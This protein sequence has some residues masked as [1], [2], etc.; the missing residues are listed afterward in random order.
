M[1]HSDICKLVMGFLRNA[2]YYEACSAIQIESGLGQGIM[3]DELIYLQKLTLQGRWDDTLRYLQPMRRVLLHNFDML[4]CMIKKQQY[5][6]ALSWLGAGGQRHSLMP[7]RPPAIKNKGDR[8]SGSALDES[9]MTF[10]DDQD[11][12]DMESVASLLKQLEGRCPQSEFNHLCTLLTLERLGDDEKYK[13]WSVARGRLACFRSLRNTLYKILPGDNDALYDD[14]NDPYEGG[15]LAHLVT[16]GTAIE[17]HR[18][19]YTAGAGPTANEATRAAAEDARLTQS[20]THVPPSAS[21]HDDASHGNASRSEIED[22][23]AEDDFGEPLNANLNTSVGSNIYFQEEDEIARQ[24]VEADDVK[25]QKNIDAAADDVSAECEDDALFTITAS[26]VRKTD[27]GDRNYT[28][29]YSEEYVSAR[30]IYSS[31]PSSPTELKQEMPKTTN[32]RTVESEPPVKSSQDGNTQII[33]D[34]DNNIEIHVPKKPKGSMLPVPLS[35]RN[36][37]RFTS[38]NSVASGESKPTSWTVDIGEGSPARRRPGSRLNLGKDSPRSVSSS[39]S[40]AS[41]GTATTVTAPRRAPVPVQK[42]PQ[43]GP[44]VGQYS[45]AEPAHYHDAP[46]LP[47]PPPLPFE[48]HVA[49]EPSGSTSVASESVYSARHGSPDKLN[50]MSRATTITSST[51]RTGG[52]LDTRATTFSKDSMS[53]QPLINQRGLNQQNPRTSTTAG[54]KVK[55]VTAPSGERSSQALAYHKAWMCSNNREPTWSVFQRAPCPLRCLHYIRSNSGDLEVLVGSNNRSISHL[56]RDGT[57]N[58]GDTT[59]TIVS[60]WIECHRG[61]VY[62]LDYSASLQLFASG[63]NDKS[64]RIGKLYPS[65]GM[66]GSTAVGELCAPMKGH[67]GTIR[68]VKF[69]PPL[70]GL[71]GGTTTPSTHLLASAGAGDNRPRLWDVST[72]CAHSTLHGHNAPVHGLTWLDGTTLLS[73]SEDGAVVAHDLRMSGAAWKY[74]IPSG[75]CTMIRLPNPQDSGNKW[76]AAGQVGGIV[77]IFNARS[78]AIMASDRLHKDDV[79]ALDVLQEP[80]QIVSSFSGTSKKVL[81]MPSLVTTSFDGTAALWSVGNVAKGGEGGFQ[82]LSKLGGAHSD[83]VLGCC[84]LP[85]SQQI[86]TSGADGI[87]A[88]W[89]PPGY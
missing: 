67:T 13:D 54:H 10:G 5:L 15:R 61:S 49:H 63:S 71:Q 83:K 11:D 20:K 47:G 9:C 22:V 79:R 43:R 53:V 44:P 16:C 56:R 76:I 24:E 21:Y 80:K 37:R 29:I 17:K 50:E 38:G 25:R 89:S 48:R 59:A 66:I 35:S 12:I 1:E 64:V 2:G 28:N 55:A 74:F 52:S 87:V 81:G 75:I 72:G 51:R 85:H 6:E 41:R 62:C 31:E 86:L 60:E 36:E 69:A 4:E 45:P 8:T 57:F 42:P 26:P 39:R 58:S 68:V 3:G 70:H 88:L 46:N 7:W 78:G 19:Q 84:A 33:M 40:N 18:H 77:S 82:L 32:Q 23:K 27:H 73:G 14:D 65:S 30:N 34:E